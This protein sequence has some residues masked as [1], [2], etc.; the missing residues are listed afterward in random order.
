MVEG[1]TGLLARTEEEW[2]RQIGR[3]L[4]DAALA[5]TLGDEGRRQTEERYE[6]T[7]IGARLADILLSFKGSS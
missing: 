3:L 1:R 7:R 5:R 6:A 2:A 4:E